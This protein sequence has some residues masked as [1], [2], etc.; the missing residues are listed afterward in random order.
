MVYGELE[1]AARD[2]ILR[3]GGSL[4]HHHGIGKIRR[5]FLPRIFSPAALEWSAEVKRAVDPANVFGIGNQTPVGGGEIAAIAA[6]DR[7]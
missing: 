3:S 5:D 7:R 4:S 6:R 2:E 1:H